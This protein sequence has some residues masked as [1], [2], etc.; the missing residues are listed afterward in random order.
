MNGT[1]SLYTN[2]R[3]LSI[4]DYSIIVEYGDGKI[5]AE[6]RLYAALE[7]KM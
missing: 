3:V 2:V 1:N 7:L 4:D 6:P 5:R